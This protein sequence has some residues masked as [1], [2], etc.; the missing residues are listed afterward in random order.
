MTQPRAL[1]LAIAMVGTSVGAAST[2]VLVDS[3]VGLL[4]R[5]TT[6]PL[7]FQIDGLAFDANGNLF[8]ALERDDPTAGVVYINKATGAV[9]TLVTGIVRADQIA[10]HAPSATFFVT[11]ESRGPASTTERIYQVTPSYDNGV[12]ISAVANSL[13]TSLTIFGPEGLVVLDSPYASAAAGDLIVGEDAVNGRILTIDDTANAGIHTASILVGAAAALDRP[14]GFAFGDFAGTVAASLY[15]AET[16]DNNVLAVASDGTVTPF[17]V[18]SAVVLTAPDNL[19]FGPDGL[20]YVTEDRAGSLGRIIRI[21]SDGTHEV[22]ATGFNLPQGLIFDSNG[23][24]YISEQGT[25]SIYR[26]TFA[27]IEPPCLLP[28]T[29]L[30]LEDWLIDMT[31][32]FEA[33][34]SIT[35]GPN[36]RIVAPGGDVTLRT[37]NTV[38]L[39]NGVSV[40]SGA[41]LTIQ[42]D[43]FVGLFLNP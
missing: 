5:L 29:D 13:T 22:F 19:E 34:N 42:L 25:N 10:Y 18:P 26:V 21:A 8:G 30:F 11:A 41:R 43:P 32:V 15:V 20:L 23:A 40:D 37:G 35:A 27:P 33:C 16:N 2:Q 31:E 14:E 7:L 6:S 9:T 38:V 3:A 1:V 24:L 28:D 36:F 4:E 12:P 39:A 17:G